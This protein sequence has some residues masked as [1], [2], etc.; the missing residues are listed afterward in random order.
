MVGAVL[1]GG[2]STRFGGSGKAQ[3][4][5]CGCSMLQRVVDRVRPQVKEVWISVQDEPGEAA[6]QGCEWV[7]DRVGRYRGPLAG[8][9]SALERLQASRADWLLLV[10]CDAPF[11]PLDLGER[12]MNAVGKG[13]GPVV[14]RYR[15]VPQPT[16]SLWHR[17][18]LPSVADTVLDR[19]RGGL[20]TVLDELQ[21]L[22][23]DWPESDPPPFFNVNTRRDLDCARRALDA[24]RD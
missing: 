18:L 14:A 13:R 4:E 1:A 2:R 11:L 12:L 21:H 9:Y 5:L 20:M 22:F 19:G 15:G 23:V 24:G 6:A 17:E 3:A 16:F 8:L 10:P 7:P